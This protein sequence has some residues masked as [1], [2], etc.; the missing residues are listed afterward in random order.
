MSASFYGMGEGAPAIHHAALELAYGI[1]RDDG[2][3]ID[4]ALFAL[5][6]LRQQFA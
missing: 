1:D 6:A 4:A 3:L 5:A 2:D